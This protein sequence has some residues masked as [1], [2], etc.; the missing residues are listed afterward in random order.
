MNINIPETRKTFLD[1]NF[2]LV[3]GIL[4]PVTLDIAEGD[5]ITYSEDKALIRYSAKPSFSDP[6]KMLPAE[7][8][9]IFMKHV[10][11][12]QTKEREVVELTTDEKANL[13]KMFRDMSTSSTVQ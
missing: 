9:I 2:T 10:A 7:N 6:T 4:F 3:S 1:I 8:V 13:Q 12:V 5:S 11:S